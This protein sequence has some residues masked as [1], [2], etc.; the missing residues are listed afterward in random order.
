QGEVGQLPAQIHGDLA[1]V[2]EDP[3]ARVAAQVVDADVEVLRNNIHDLVGG[4]LRAGVAR[5]E[6]AQDVFGEAQVDDRPVQA[7]VRG[8]LGQS[9]LQVPDRVGDARRDELQHLRRYQ[10]AF[11]SRLLLQDRDPGLEVGWLDVG[12]ESPLEPGA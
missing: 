4:D 11:L 12:E 8:D 2:H 3:R 10:Q 6:V 7:R 5:D 1:G 9:G